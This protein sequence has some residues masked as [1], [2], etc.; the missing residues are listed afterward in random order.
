MRTKLEAKCIRTTVIGEAAEKRV[1][2]KLS[3]GSSSFIQ[4]YLLQNFSH[5]CLPH[6]VYFWRQAARC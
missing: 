5:P 3:V 1:R 2:D 4:S 6:V